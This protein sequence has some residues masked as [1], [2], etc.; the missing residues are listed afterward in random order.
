M[1]DRSRGIL[2][3]LT[4][5]FRSS[6][7]IDLRLWGREPDGEPVLLVPRDAD[8]AVARELV[9]LPASR[10]R[11]AV[12]LHGGGEAEARW[13]AFARDLLDQV[14]VYQRELE[15]ER[16]RLSERQREI[17][18]LHSISETLGLATGLEEA[19]GRILEEVV[20][21]TG[22]RRA[23]LWVYRPE[24]REL[25]L[26]ASE[27]AGTPPVT[28]IPVDSDRSVSAL[29][30]REGRTVRLG[31]ELDVPAGL[32]ERFPTGPDPW[33]AMPVTHTSPAGSTRTV[34]VLNLIGGDAE[35][36]GRSSRETRLLTTLARQIGSA[37]ANLRLFEENLSRERLVRE[38][39][40]A[41]ELQM[42]LLPDLAEFDDL[43]EV[44]GRCV[45]ARPVGGD[46]YQLFRLANG[47]LGVMLGDV[48]SHGFAAALVMALSTSAAVIHAREA[49]A[50]GDLLR[51]IHRALIQKLESAEMFLTLFYGVIDPGAGE[52]SYANAGH[53]H[54]FHL[55]GDAE[56]V[57]LGATSPP[58]G[59]AEYGAYADAYVEWR[60]GDLLSLFTDGLTSPSLRATERSLVEAIHE[61][62]NR[63][64][65]EIVEAIFRTR[66]QL[67]AAVPDDQT[68]LV[69]RMGR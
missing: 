21:L 56:P 69:V 1:P 12:E 46:F 45:P 35:I 47:R 27:G 20:R 16:Q 26:A 23:S 44:A 66:R 34:G 43:G 36:G 2:I 14:L 50:A 51:A 61:N 60:D 63:S 42:K 65:A 57:R 10:G 15:E 39:H 48:T 28:H 18:L 37:I 40:L 31:E 19:C 22:A 49:E 41:Q 29:A 55:S 59:I 53:P 38:L 7:E 68:A 13:L 5:R 62:R 25:A 33:L 3:E 67:Q 24:R 30:F 8:G 17:Q 4:E 58:L 6:A 9:W 64:A 32:I 11:Y 52:L 54:A